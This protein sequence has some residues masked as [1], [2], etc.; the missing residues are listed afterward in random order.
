M[1]VIDATGKV[2]GRLASTVAKMLLNGE[3]ISVINAEKAVI[4]GSPDSIKNLYKIRLD[5]GD[6][7]KGPFMSR[8]PD[9]MLKRMVRGMLPY[10]KSLGRIALRRLRVFIG[11]PK[12]L[13][14]KTVEISTKGVSELTSEH[15]TLQD[16]SHKLGRKVV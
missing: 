9:R 15:I 13:A 3:D 10:K 14:D 11:A 6:K 2:C 1:K 4:S 7:Y 5:R 16:L 8:L 12:E